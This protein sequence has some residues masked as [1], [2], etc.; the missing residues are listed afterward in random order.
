MACNISLV[1]AFD[2]TDKIGMIGGFKPNFWIFNLSDVVS[3]TIDL[4][5]NVTN[6]TLKA[7]KKIYKYEA[8]K[9]TLT[10]TAGIKKVEGSGIA[11]YTHSVNFASVDTTAEQR[12]VFEN[13]ANAEA[14]AVIAETTSGRFEIFGKDFGMKLGDANEKNYGLNPTEDTSR[15]VSLTSAGEV[16]LPKI[17]FDTDRAVTLAKIVALETPQP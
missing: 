10:A 7:T 14:V 16:Y 3:Y 2:C 6:I 15:K 11:I 5:G 12:E 13:L 1:S 9:D 17:F 4:A 8:L